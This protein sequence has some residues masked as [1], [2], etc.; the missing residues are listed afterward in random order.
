MQPK[1]LLRRAG[2]VPSTAFS[3]APPLHAIASQEVRAAPRPGHAS[4]VLF[5]RP[6]WT[7][8]DGG[9]RLHAFDLDAGS[10]V[11]DDEIVAVQ[12]FLAERLA[13]DVQFPHSPRQRI[14][15]AGANA[16]IEGAVG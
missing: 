6:Q 14:G 1:V 3:T 8:G 13:A 5:L 4:P 10:F 9:S 12:Q 15:K 2:I 16:A 11:I 7:R